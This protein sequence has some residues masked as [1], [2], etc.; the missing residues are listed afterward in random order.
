MRVGLLLLAVSTAWGADVAP[1][2]VR[3]AAAK[4]LALIQSTQKDWYTRRSCNS[5]H[6]QMLPALAVR[7][8]REHG[9]PLNGDAARAH[10]A[11]AFAFLTGLDKAVQYTD[12]VDP[13]MNDGY[14]LLAAHAAG[15]ASSLTTAVIARH[16]AARQ[17][18]D[19]HWLTMDNRPPQAYSNVTATA[20][21]LRAM[22][23]YSHPSLAADSKARTGRAA[24]WLAAISPHDTEE[25]TYQL[26]GLFWAGADRAQ[27]AR[28]A[29]ELAA[30]QQP[31]GGWN[32]LGGRT[33]DAYST[34]QALAVLHEAGG[35]SISDPA[36]RRGLQYLLDTQAAD[37]SWH[38]ASRLHPPAELSPP[39]F[40]SGYPYGHD[41]F[42]SAMGSSWAVEALASAL[43]PA[44]GN[45]AFDLP[46]AAPK[47]VEPWVETALFG[48][49]A[50]LR[51]ALDRGLDPNAATKSGGTTLLMLAQ[52][53]LEKTKLLLDRGANIDGRAKSKYSALMLAC[54]Y[55]GAARTVRLLLDRGA[56]MRP[57]KGA[58]APLHN[59]S[60]L[61]LASFGGN[62]DIIGRLIQAGARLDE[63]M[64]IFGVFP[65]TP[66]AN[67]IGFG[68]LP[69]IR[70]L[71]DA[72]A[73]PDEAD[74]DGFTLL[75]S[76]VVGNL[77]DV[78]RLLIER[79]AKVN[80]VD[81]RGMTPLLYAASADYGDAAMVDLLLKMGANPAARTKEGLTAQDLA[82][83]YGHSYL[84][85][86]LTAAAR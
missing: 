43:G 83:K 59:A 82:R 50:D 66:T 54:L 72:G 10:A 11:R 76:A 85:G 79:R 35:V 12:I 32:A 9:I 44:S 68:D 39:Y 28:L 18:P 21:A 58:G 75:N 15:V 46:E 30:R 63:K 64:L 17:Q 38:V 8:A 61:M 62:A 86:L 34:G 19:G 40:E 5:C 84:A 67:A 29:H 69:T 70:A 47:D 42:L 56:Q 55:P 48:S 14:Q 22:Q 7:A 1:E 57:P 53:D 45:G 77:T 80:A 37:G 65:S 23:L 49:A 41:Q 78:A 6:Q 31:D 24:H 20:V 74:G 33:S 36:W 3:D 52:P 26:Y 16:I 60:P 71:L 13:A 25:R 51:Q 4:A 2:R 27:I 81:W 73:D